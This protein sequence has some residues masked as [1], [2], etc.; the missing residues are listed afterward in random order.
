MSQKDSQ[1]IA[2]SGSEPDAVRRGSTHGHTEGRLHRDVGTDAT[3]MPVSIHGHL[4]PPR[5]LS[6]HLMLA[7]VGMGI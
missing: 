3:T 2:P 5:Q 6:G 7:L 4:T 1:V